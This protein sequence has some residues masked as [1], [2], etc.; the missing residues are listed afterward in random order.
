MLEAFWTEISQEW[1]SYAIFKIAAQTNTNGHICAV[2]GLPPVMNFGK[3]PL[4]TK[5]MEE[6]LSGKKKI[7]L[8][9]SEAY[10]GS[11]ALALRC[12]A[13]KQADGS[14]LISGHKKW[15]TNG[16]FSDYFSVAARTGKS[17]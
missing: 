6:V 17:L 8:A 15:I 13:D 2:I 14:F 11:D 10:A 16:S 1:V 12:R 9:I 7:S 4:R 3:E 5:I